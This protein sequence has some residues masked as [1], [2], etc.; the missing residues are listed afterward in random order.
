MTCHL[1]KGRRAISR[2]QPWE[3]AQ[4]CRLQDRGSGLPADVCWGLQPMQLAEGQG[5]C[6]WPLQGRGYVQALGKEPVLNELVCR[7]TLTEVQV[8][9][10][11]LPSTSQTLGNWSVAEQRFAEPRR[12]TDLLFPTT[13]QPEAG[14][15]C[16]RPKLSAT[17][18]RCSGAAWSLGAGEQSGP[19]VPTTCCA[20]VTESR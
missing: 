17:A 18:Q 7:L 20:E 15:P 1:P 13:L 10:S 8:L 2:G 9:E 4:L 16:T 5:L 12:G 6:L 3:K 14:L 11:L 19:Q